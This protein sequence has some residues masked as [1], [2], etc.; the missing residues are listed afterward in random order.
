MSAPPERLVESLADR[1]RI[2][3]ELGS[4]GM[5][6]VY[7]AQDVRHDR[8]V[9]VKVLRPELA[10][11]IGAERFLA[12]IKVTANLQHPHILALH[13]SGEVTT[14]SPGHGEGSR[15]VFY[16]MPY[17][18]GESLRD[19]LHREKQL[20]VDEAVRIAREVASAL[21]YAHRKNVIHRDIK[22]ENILLH[23][24][25]ALVADFGIA[26]AVTTAGDTRMTETGMSL[27]T[28]SYMS[29]EQ[30]MGER[31]ITVRSDVYALG[32][33]LYEMLTGEPP[34]TGPT[35]QAIVARVVTDSP[36]SMQAQRHT[37][38]AHIEAAVRTALEKLPA[39]RF[40]SAAEFAAALGDTG[41]G[42][43]ATESVAGHSAPPLRDRR[44]MIAAG[45]GVVMTGLA[46]WGWLRPAPAV[47]T[48]R[49]EIPLP[50]SARNPDGIAVT[51]DGQR[52]VINAGSRLYVRALGDFALSPIP[53]TERASAGVSVS[54]DGAEVAF[55]QGVALRAIPL[56][57]GAPRTIADTGYVPVWASNGNV[58]F[59]GWNNELAWA[60]QAGGSVEKLKPTR[61]FN[62]LP[63]PLPGGRLVLYT[64]G[65][66][67]D[68]SVIRIHDLQAQSD[69]T[70]G[71]GWAAR[72]LPTGE[73]LFVRNGFLLAAPF[74]IESLRFTAPPVPLLEGLGAQPWWDLN[75]GTLA[76]ATSGPS[77]QLRPL[78]VTL[79]GAR[80]PLANL[81]PGQIF[82]FPRASPDGRRIAFRVVDAQGK[83]D[84]WIYTLPEGPLTRLT[85][86]GLQADDPAWTPDGRSISYGADQDSTRRLFIQAADGSDEP[87]V[88]FQGAP[89]PWTSE[90]LP[91]GR[92]FLF[93]NG[94]TG[95]AY[96]IGMGV[97]GAPDSAVMLLSTPAD[98][99]R[100]SLSPDGRWMA[101][102]SNE[103][104]RSEIFVRPVDG[105]GR[106]QIS[107]RGGFSPR[108]SHSG[109]QI[110]FR[111]ADSLYAV[112]VETGTAVTPRRTRAILDLTRI[113]DQWY[114]VLPG[115]TA[116]VMM[117]VDS[118]T[119]DSRV[120]VITNFLEELQ[121]RL[122]K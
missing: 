85:F 5:A 70:L 23:D 95:V 92:R 34:F 44:L 11:V 90:W 91:D 59:T 60:S 50:D 61:G 18:E 100:P 4:G 22:P 76:V 102:S 115:D 14:G 98:E 15:T 3:R 81:P 74:D 117:G 2:E 19:R 99:R 30:A 72:L 106:W 9:A 110:F 29:P 89:S 82:G 32:C 48:Y 36:R 108:W 63:Q 69:T 53:G 42:T 46:A 104:G 88:L 12:E 37:I 58:Y 57:G 52:I 27:G 80:R 49:L 112:D 68:S 1:Y 65:M 40:A 107:S 31:Q 17:V 71:P 6:T 25:Q 87:R 64:Q 8:Q 41:Y 83:Q 28:P 67:L 38:P 55:N 120:L 62:V 45:V 33:V 20:P 10:A 21:D 24:G 101:Y 73:M 93:S 35:A 54:P 118:P 113:V 122:R 77:A 47:P 16:V 13:D 96:D 7:L 66:S 119:S 97:V 78:I 39:D 51:P 86:S 103:S 79:S 75:G 121:R 84:I 114:D 109:K 26:L 43:Q 56:A 111:T 105:S 116:F 94:P